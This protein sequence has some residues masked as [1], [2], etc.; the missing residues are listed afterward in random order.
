MDQKSS[1]GVWNQNGDVIGPQNG[2]WQHRRPCTHTKS[3]APTDDLLWS[4]SGLA[5]WLDCEGGDVGRIVGDLTAK[6][7]LS[8]K[9]MWFRR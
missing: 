1:V 2:K 7:G 9:L 8:A 5:K 4:L 3:D 6:L